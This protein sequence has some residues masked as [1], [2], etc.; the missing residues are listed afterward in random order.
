MHTLLS[1]LGVSPELRAF[2]DV[3]DDLCF[4]YGDEQ[5]IYG[6]GYH[7]VPVSNDMWM[8]GSYPA[9]ELIISSSA[10]EAIAYMALN[11]WRHP[12]EG[13]LSFIAVGLRPQPK[14][15]RWIRKYCLKRKIT[16]VFPNDICGR[17]ADIIIAAGIRNR[18]VTA[19][20]NKG[21]VQLRLNTLTVE[22]P[23]QKVSL[24]AFEKV[25]SLRTGIRTRKPA[26]FNTFLDQL[27]YENK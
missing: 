23:A 4:S 21:S 9:T 2:F 12:A 7:H 10:M 6:P 27:R 16:L 15:L 1:E 20:W 11:A 18:P 26:R 5:E 8:S 3:Q 19:L 17:L 24:N 13:S 22:L 14:Q 25:A